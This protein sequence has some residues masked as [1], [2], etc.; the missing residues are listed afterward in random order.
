MNSTIPGESNEK[1]TL[2]ELMVLQNRQVKTALPLSIQ[3]AVVEAGPGAPWK[4][5]EEVGEMGRCQ[6]QMLEL[7]FEE[8]TES[9]QEAHVQRLHK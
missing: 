6:G 9:L 7:H 5:G 4:H 3:S 2:K 1:Q 8:P